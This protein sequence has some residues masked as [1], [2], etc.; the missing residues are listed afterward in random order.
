MASGPIVFQHG[1][2]K[3]ELFG[4][5]FKET[6]DF[7]YIK[8]IVA[9]LRRNPRTTAEAMSSLC[10]IPSPSRDE[11]YRPRSVWDFL[12][13]SKNLHLI[14]YF[15]KQRRKIWRDALNG[16]SWIILSH[17]NGKIM[18]ATDKV[19]LL[20]YLLMIDSN[21]RGLWPFTSVLRSLEARQGPT[22]FE[23]IKLA[24]TENLEKRGV[25]FGPQTVVHKLQPVLNWAADL[26][27]VE[28]EKRNYRITSGGKVIAG[29]HEKF[30]ESG[31]GAFRKEAGTKI[32]E[33]LPHLVLGT[34]EA[35]ETSERVFEESIKEG[36]KWIRTR[37]KVMRPIA[38]PLL[39]NV[40]CTRLLAQG[41]AINDL[42]F[43]NSLLQLSK[44]HYHKYTLML[45]RQSMDYPCAG[46]KAPRGS[47]YYFDLIQ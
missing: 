31:Y 5:T 15:V 35:R 14:S 4:S 24:F 12:Y 32:S 21:N 25:S 26:G 28:R 3:P 34:T 11:F 42:E 39:R 22:E 18:S 23:T 7:S 30:A 40:C 6:G 33:A 37:I 20:R 2:G 38:I 19:F 36:V 10:Q 27:L 9:E 16:A 1:S 47:F 8:L 13:A 44:R 29:L 41:N 17:Q 46:I 43:D 45:S